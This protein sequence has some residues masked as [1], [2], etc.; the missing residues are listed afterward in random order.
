MAAFA[1]TGCTWGGEHTF[2]LTIQL[3]TATEQ[4]S[5]GP[6][7]SNPRSIL[8]E[9]YSNVTIVAYLAGDYVHHTKEVF[10][11]VTPGT[12]SLPITLGGVPLGKSTL[13]IEAIAEWEDNHQQRT[14]YYAEQEITVTGGVNSYDI[15]MD[16]GVIVKCSSSGYSGK[17][18]GNGF[19]FDLT[20][21]GDKQIGEPPL[22]DGDFLILQRGK[23]ASEQRNFAS[24]L[25][26]L[27][28]EG[29]EF[30]GYGV[31]MGSSSPFPWLSDE[32]VR[33]PKDTDQSSGYNEYMDY[34]YTRYGSPTWP[35]YSVWEEED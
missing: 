4:L 35:L 7:D 11:N 32:R 33:G 25:R 10:E 28:A 21:T 9:G 2:D 31:F 16:Y 1:F 27:T 24:R 29:Y 22:A 14:G 12:I 6:S 30:K 19:I 23:K 34:N 26:S 8:P 18:D 20:G 15:Y 5:K 3:P 13:V 17:P